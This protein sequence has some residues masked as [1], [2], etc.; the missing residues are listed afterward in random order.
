MKIRWLVV[1]VAAAFALPA[2]GAGDKAKSDASATPSA[3]QGASGSS[4]ASGASGSAASGATKSN[5]GAE[6][7]FKSLDKNNDGFITKEEA[8]G[9]PHD[10]D[11]ATLDKNSDGKLSPEEH[12]AAPEHAGD[13][14]ATGGTSGGG[15]KKQ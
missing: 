7:M 4:G 1:A 13:K 2:Y 14:A 3:S 12:A 8:Q 5:G 11:F 15:E 6:A 9:T 10:K